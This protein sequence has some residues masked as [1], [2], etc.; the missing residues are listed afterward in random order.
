MPTSLLNSDS[1]DFPPTARIELAANERTPTVPNGTVEGFVDLLQSLSTATDEV[2]CKSFPNPGEMFLGFHLLEELGRGAFGRVFVARQGDLHGRLVALKVARDIFGE[3]QTLAQLQHSNIVPIYSYHRLDSLQAVCMPY[4]GRTTLADVFVNVRSRMN[5]PHSGRDLKSTV[6]RHAAETIPSGGSLAA[7]TEQ[8]PTSVPTPVAAPTTEPG[9]PDGWDRLDGLSYVEAVLCLGAQLADG[10][11]HAHRRGILHRDLK[12]ANV[13]LTDDGRPMLLDFNLAEDT[14]LRH[15]TDRA[16]AGG[17]LPYM[18]PEQM[19]ILLNRTGELDGRADLFA[20]GV[21]LFELLT[22]RNPYP[23]HKGQI[24]DSAKAMLFDRLQ[25]PPSPRD[26]NRDVS[27]A[28]AAIVRKCLAPDPALRYQT[29]EQLRVDIERHLSHRPLKFAPNP[30]TKERLVK[31]GRRH[32]RLSSSGS[33]ATLAVI[34][35]IGAGAAWFVAAE[36]ARNLDARAQYADHRTKFAEVQ[37]FLDDRNQSRSRLDEGF[38]RLNDLLS[39]Y[40]ATE[41]DGWL[42]NGPARRL[43]AAERNQLKAD[44]GEVFFRKAE[45]GYL[46]ALGRADGPERSEWLAKAGQWNATA[47]RYAWDR[48]PGAVRSQ[49]QALDAIRSRT[50][51]PP[52][53]TA[54]FKSA[55]DLALIGGQL[56]QLGRPRDALPLLRQATQIDPTDFSAWFVRGT[57]HLALEQNELAAMSFGAC[58][59]IRPEFAPAWRNRGLAFSRMHFFDQAADDYDRAVKLAPLVAET[60]LQRAAVKDARGNLA[61]AEADYTTGLALGS[62]PVRTYFL[63]ADVRERRGKAAGAKAD[64]EDG[65]R[66][67]PNDELSWIGRAELQE[68]T[69]PSA[70]LNDVEQALKV[71]PLSLPGLQMKAHLLAE[72]LHRGE[73]AIAVLNRAV[74]LFPDSAPARAGRGVLLARQGHRAEALQDAKDALLLDGNSPNLYQVGC[75]FALTSK[76]HPDDTADALR[77]LWAA[78][79]TGFGLDLV[80]GDPDLDPLRTNPEF[81]KI[82]AKARGL[83]VGRK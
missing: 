71:N 22:G 43:P 69:D 26:G 30:S 25:P 33:V 58:L 42:T 5:F 70:A 17:T 27:P 53:S 20:L 3:S 1:H 36:R 52:P 8:P 67:I 9:A 79:K 65:L 37:L 13:L 34:L 55:R 15:T 18:A 50:P 64:R 45:L 6:H 41:D 44:V 40:G 4:F 56:A 68:E 73:D 63:R 57:V 74:D 48:I 83:E 2:P 72:R 61:A 31:W 54:E 49:R 24:R 16:A 11:A 82:V 60:Y 14:K 75:I 62:A 12:P 78:L 21:I 47:E 66:L 80:D 46:E 39:P 76:A 59:A 7:E 29:A 32:P 19:H 23:S 10:L 81:G 51:S 28:A 35:L 77:N 38:V